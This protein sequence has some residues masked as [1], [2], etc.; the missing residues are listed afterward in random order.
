MQILHALLLGGVFALAAPSAAAESLRC[1][2]GIVAEGDSRLSV[3][4]K[5]G[6]PQLR[7]QF[8]APVFYKDKGMLRRL[9]GAVADVHLPCVPV[10]LWLYER[11]PGNLMATVRIQS[12]A[13]QSIVYG[14]VPE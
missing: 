7:D 6:Q 2:G 14:H 1:Q 5:C 8:C 12:G 13:V 9:P 3:V 11:G 10:E 4:H